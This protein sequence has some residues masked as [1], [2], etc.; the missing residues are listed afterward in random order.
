MIEYRVRSMSLLNLV[1][2]IRAGR[3]VPDA[4]FQRNLVWRDVHKREFIE[5]ILKGYPFPQIFIS[6]GKVDV[7]EMTTISCIVDGQQRCNAIEMFLAEEF[8]VGGRTFSSL[9]DEEKSAFLKYD[10]PVIE[11]DLEND[12]PKVQ[13][14]FQRINRTSSSLTSIE[15]LASQY[16][17]S[18]FMLV[19][20]LLVNQVSLVPSRDEDFREDPNITAEFYAWA[21]VQRVKSIQKL[22]SEKGVF[23]YQEI[24][25]KTNLMHVL[26]VMA[27]LLGGY[28]NRN[29]KAT[30][31]LDDFALSFEQRDEVVGLIE[32]SANFLL[33]LGFKTK[34]YWLNKANVF[35][36]L[37]VIAA[38]RRE[39]VALDSD[40]V[41]VN[42][43]RFEADLPA[44]YKLAA[45]EG[46]NSTKARQLRDE[47][48]RTVLCY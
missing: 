30:D 31:L 32:E 8:E 1:N 25:R 20:K 18:E 44:D 24:A 27:T 36:L 38:L 40:R 37:V 2:D 11:L 19:A 48:L 39:G 26:N 46:V 12:D 10:V 21:K 9:A 7:E 16:S 41:Q 45:A 14:I 43:G 6:K 5:T 15:K 42:L 34:S 47:Y 3:L 17:T 35:S 22:M 13:E 29:E 23:T 4:Y 28:F 33:S